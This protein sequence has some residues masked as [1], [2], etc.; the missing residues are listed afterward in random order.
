VSDE[1]TLVAAVLH[2]TVEDTKTTFEEVEEH[3]GPDVAGVVREVTD[4]KSLPKIERKRL[5]QIEHALG[6][7]ARAKQL[8][9]ADKISNVRDITVCPPAN[10]TPERRGDY[11]DWSTAVVANCR[12]V[13]QKL[14][15]AFDKA[16]IQARIVLNS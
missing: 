3:F 12:G 16:I 13:N 1:V 11:L 14:D 6:A 10:W 15:Q 7:S 9:I 8:K 5:L 2:D 4:D